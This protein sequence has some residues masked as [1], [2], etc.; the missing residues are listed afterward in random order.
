MNARLPQASKPPV[1]IAMPTGNSTNTGI[2]ITWWK[3]RV[4]R[5]CRTTA[6]GGAP[7]R[8]GQLE[9]RG[10]GF[11]TVSAGVAARVLRGGSVEQFDQQHRY[12]RL[13]CH[14]RPVSPVAAARPLPPGGA[15]GTATLD[16]RNHAPSMAPIP[17]RQF[18]LRSPGIGEIRARELDVP[19][20]GPAVRVRTLFSGISRGTESLVFRGEVPPSQYGAM[21]SPFQEGD[22]PG[23]VKYGYSS[24]GVVEATTGSLPPHLPAELIGRPVFALY[25]HQDVYWVPADAVAPLPDG[26]PPGRAVLAANLETAVNV[27]WDGAPG[28]GD[29]VVVVGGGVVGLLVAWL[30]R[31]IPG[32]RVTV[33]DIDP[34]RSDVARA[35]GLDFACWDTDAGGPRAVDA[36]GPL[37]PGTADLVFHTS[38]HPEGL[39]R[40]LALAGD[41]AVLVEASWFGTRSVPLPLGESFH[42]RRLTLRSSQV[43][44]IPPAR[45]PRWTYRRRMALAL[46]LL[47]A[48]ELDVL[49]S[50]ESAFEEL[51]VVMGRLAGAPVGALC[52]RIR[53]P[54]A[55]PFS[56]DRGTSDVQP[57]RP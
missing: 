2:A 47:R 46:E 26:V 38:G 36:H 54:G 12:T 14:R 49:I 9:A 55:E 30:C 4:T 1:V 10:S 20:G 33:I 43:G 19:A 40:G 18:W 34:A 3:I 45:A 23:P 56:F 31:P 57:E 35:L 5:W 48:P 16:P 37:A 8:G 21:R 44:R 41:E 15:P 11:M 32:C 25:P 24:V 22:F 42:A 6:T 28:P 13:L 51:P 29:R 7:A 17:S 52:H 53:Y 50:G 39:A 27:V